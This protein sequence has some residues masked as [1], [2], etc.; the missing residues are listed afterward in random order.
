MQKIQ[1]VHQLTAEQLEALADTVVGVDGG[2]VFC[3]R[4]VLMGLLDAFPCEDWRAAMAAAVER[5]MPY[6]PYWTLDE[7]FD[8]GVN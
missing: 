4:H 2:C 5:S 1:Q 6:G 8:F 7:L 3:G